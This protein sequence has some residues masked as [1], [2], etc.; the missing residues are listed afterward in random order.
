MLNRGLERFAPGTHD[1]VRDLVDEAHRTALAVPEL[2]RLARTLAGALHS[3]FVLAGI[4][5]LGALLVTFFVP[6]REQL[7]QEE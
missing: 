5:A 6:R 2:E 1:I 3:V 7:G 4:I